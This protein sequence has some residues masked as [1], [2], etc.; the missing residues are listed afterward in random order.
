M[1]DLTEFRDDGLSRL[2]R[3]DFEAAARAVR[4]WESAHPLAFEDYLRFLESFQEMFGPLAPTF[5][6]IMIGRPRL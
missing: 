1:S 6:R 3:D 2:R 5:D 4:A